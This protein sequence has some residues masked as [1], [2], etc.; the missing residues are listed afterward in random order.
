MAMLEMGLLDVA[1]ATKRTGEDNVAPLLGELTVTLAK[2]EATRKMLAVN[3]CTTFFTLNT[4]S[5]KCVSK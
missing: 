1:E 2:A 4:S 3:S 5:I